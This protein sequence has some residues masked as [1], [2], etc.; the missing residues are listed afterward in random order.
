MAEKIKMKVTNENIDKLNNLVK[1][2]YANHENIEVV[3]KTDL[4]QR[5]LSKDGEL[6]LRTSGT[7]V[8]Q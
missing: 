4:R 8:K 5:F 1:K 3:L 7:K 2:T 6:H